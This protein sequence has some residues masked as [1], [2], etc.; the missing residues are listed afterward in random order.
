MKK[1]FMSSSFRGSCIFV[2]ILSL[3]FCSSAFGRYVDCSKVRG[4]D[5]CQPKETTSYPAVTGPTKVSLKTI[6]N[7]DTPFG[8]KRTTISNISGGEDCWTYF[9]FNVPYGTKHFAVEVS[10]K[11]QSDVT[12]Y[13]SYNKE[14][15]RYWD[16]GVLFPPS[17]TL[18]ERYSPFAWPG[19]WY[20][21]VRG[22]ANYSNVNLEI[23]TWDYW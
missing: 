9:Y 2:L 6:Q 13:F 21:G 7:G 4:R 1:C 12:V 22:H 10:G 23:T 3:F 16:D 18:Y 19:N 14:P 17:R 15:S 5:A 11:G 20:I 8:V